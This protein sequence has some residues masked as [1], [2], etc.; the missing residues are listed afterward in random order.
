M[1]V[2][3][4]LAGAAVRRGKWLLNGRPATLSLLEMIW[5]QSRFDAPPAVSVPPGHTLRQYQAADRDAYFAMLAAADM[6][7]CRLEYWE[8]H[9]LPNGFFVIEHDESG[10]LVAACM[11]SHHP[12][13]RHPRAGNL[14][15]LAA[16]PAHKGKQLGRSVAAAV[17][18]RLVAGGYRRIYL[19]THD[20]RLA[21]ITLYLK[22]GWVP[23]LYQDDMHDRWK[24]IC[25]RAGFEFTPNEWA[26]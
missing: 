22:M 20:H 24:V 15:W 5:P 21:A 23:L 1:S 8:Q 2:V 12:A 3:R 9:L 17:T 4:R 19:E 13:P 14:G 11:A 6:G 26:R 7:A 16:D 18:A 10:A 25:E